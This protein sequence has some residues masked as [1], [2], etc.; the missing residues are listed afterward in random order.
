MVLREG[1]WRTVRSFDNAHGPE[2]HHEHRYIGD[3]KQAPVVSRGLVNEAMHAAEIK[4]L[5]GWSDILD[6]W[7]KTR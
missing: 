2:E 5:N 6:S 1:A 3:E 4:L 7:E